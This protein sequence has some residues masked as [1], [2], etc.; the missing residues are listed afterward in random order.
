MKNDYYVYLHKTLDGRLFY[1]GKGRNNRAWNRSQRS[2]AWNEIAVGIYSVEIY[3]EGLSET[4]ALEIENNLIKTSE[5]LVNSRILLPVKFDDYGDYFAYDPLSPSGLT[6]IK[7]ISIGKKVYSPIGYCGSKLKRACG[8]Y[9]WVISFRE[10]TV[11]VHRVIW[12][13]LNG[14]IPD[15]MVIDHIDGNALNN[16]INN[17]RLVT[18]LENNRNTQR[19]K[20]SS[21]GVTGVVLGQNNGVKNSRWVASCYNTEGERIVKYFSILKLGNEEAFRQACEWRSEQIRLLNEQ[22]AGYTE[23]HGT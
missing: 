17:L 2:K 20:N 1:V 12:Q 16:N 13:L 9:N 15:G 21:S 10:R 11:Q 18:R 22:G 19:C 3:R 7:E 5:G 23:R 6:R 8:G 4:E 14:N